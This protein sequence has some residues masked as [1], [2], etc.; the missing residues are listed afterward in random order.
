MASISE[1]LGTRI[2]DVLEFTYENQKGE[3]KNRK[4]TVSEVYP[5][6]VNSGTSF[7]LVIEGTDAYANNEHRKFHVSSIVKKNV[8]KPVSVTTNVSVKSKIRWLD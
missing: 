8:T 1:Y 5:Q 2:G 3:V 6:L 7:D 4:V